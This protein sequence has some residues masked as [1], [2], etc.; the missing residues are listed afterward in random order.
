MGE[1]I[2]VFK[3]LN[4]CTIIFQ[5]MG[6]Q[7]FSLDGSKSL[8]FNLGVIVVAFCLAAYAYSFVLLIQSENLESEN[9]VA[10]YVMMS[11]TVCVILTAI[12]ASIIISYAMREKSQNI[13]L[14]MAQ[15]SKI[16]TKDL[17]HKLDYA[18]LGR[19]FRNFSIASLI[20]FMF[21]AGALLATIHDQSLE[22]LLAIAFSLFPH[23]F[24]G[25]CF[26]RFIFYVMLIKFHVDHIETVL[27]KFQKNRVSIVVVRNALWESQIK[28]ERLERA[29]ESV[30]FWLAIKKI[31]GL[32]VK[33]TDG[34]NKICGFTS[35]ILFGLIVFANINGLYDLYLVFM[36]DFTGTESAGN[37]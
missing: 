36:A 27:K 20:A 35:L 14:S 2:D 1:K 37:Y 22:F 6:L 13:F 8:K 9:V 28:L 7:F 12:I 15:V 23:A 26:V 33:A 16:Y 10:S 17:K 3:S 25:T 19:R 34:V 11:V 24:L 18:T 30:D 21:V 29:G 5:L 31:Y 4:N 32:L